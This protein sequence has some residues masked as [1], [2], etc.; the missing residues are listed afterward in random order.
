M[1]TTNSV[2]SLS[3]HMLFLLCDMHVWVI[4]AGS[5]VYMYVCM[6]VC[7]YTCACM[8]CA[9]KPVCSVMHAQYT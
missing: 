9:L 3:T 6:Y 1:V 8:Q 4:N 7:V 2:A 5:L